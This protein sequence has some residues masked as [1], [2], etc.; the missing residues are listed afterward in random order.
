M[1]RILTINSGFFGKL[2]ILRQFAMFG[3]VFLTVYQLALAADVFSQ[4]VD[5]EK[6]T[7]EMERHPA[8]S[9]AREITERNACRLEREVEEMVEDFKSVPVS[10]RR[11]V[12]HKRDSMA[13]E[14]KAPSEAP[15]QKRM[16]RGSVLVFVSET[17][18]VEVLQSYARDLQAIGKERA[19]FVFRGIPSKELLRQM[20][21]PDP[22]CTENC[23]VFSFRVTIS[24]RLF[25][26][27]GIEKVP[28]V[29]FDPTEEAP[30]KDF[31]LVYGAGPLN[32]AF[33]LFSSRGGYEFTGSRIP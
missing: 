26:A 33:G 30:G 1:L 10:V 23:E 3:A 4:E 21:K 20:A 8:W 32:R 14:E 15:V 13:G 22:G 11:A 19:R 25:R 12:D 6:I 5:V 24:A 29:L 18:P 17:I 28:A 27:Y 31:L 2:R 16:D 9:R 7:R